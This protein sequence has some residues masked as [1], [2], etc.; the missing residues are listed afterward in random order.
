MENLS[1]KPPNNTDCTKTDNEEVASSERSPPVA[2]S[3]YSTDKAKPLDAAFPNLSPKGNILATID[4]AQH[5]LDR[6]GIIV[7]YNVITKKLLI[8]VPGHSGTPDNA[9]NV[10]MT[11]IMSLASLN[12]MS[13]GQ[14]P[15]YVAA[16][17]D[18][19]QFNPVAEWVMSKPWDG[20]DRLKDICATLVSREG[21]PESLKNLIL[22]RWLISAVAA[23]LKP[24]GFKA[25]GV[26]TLQGPQLLGKTS[27]ISS[28]VPD[29][30]LREGTVK[31][32]HHLDAGNKDSL[33]T[34]LSH[35]IV[36][37]GELDSSFK[38]DIARLK[39][40]LTGDKDKIRIPY[41]R[42]NSEFPRR[43]VFAATV[44]ENNFLVDATGNS[45]FWTI[46][47]VK[48]NYNHG[49]DM[50]QL[51]AQ[52]ATYFHAGEQWW[53][54]PEEDAQLDLQNKEYRSI[55]AIAERVLS[56]IDLKRVDES[57]L[58]AMSPSELLIKLDIKNPTNTQCKECAA[59]LR[60]YLGESK[61][62]NGINK[63][64]VPLAQFT[65]S[66]SLNTATS[67]SP[68]KAVPTG[69]VEHSDDEF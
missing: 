10:A 2:A 59:I 58:R 11:R 45:R 24:I 38:K 36:E 35:W 23:V 6:Y 39:G 44:N 50:Q 52:M 20:R 3:S 64:R 1:N 43:T 22:R 57:D 42:T 34:A 31:L 28:L 8:T 14:L 66:A 19:N 67:A 65:Y 15:S 21:Y 9:D 18:R 62:I 69:K 7:R 47:V 48:V 56:A 30:I 25:R 40:F 46:S 61:R 26:L 12:A 4:N 16:I 33:I 54:T 27:W 63:W 13:I 5:L 17:G 41:A 29:Q 32:D 49:I 53:L 68:A 51:W 55:S 60:E 37:I